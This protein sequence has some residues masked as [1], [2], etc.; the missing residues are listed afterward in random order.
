MRPS[1]EI[2]A[3]VAELVQHTVERTAQ[4]W[5]HRILVKRTAGSTGCSI[6][7]SNISPRVY[8]IRIITK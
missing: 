1:S 4:P 3:A 2:I 5:P 7:S 6:G 8:K